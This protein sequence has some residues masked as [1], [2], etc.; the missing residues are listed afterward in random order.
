M[1]PAGPNRWLLVEPEKRDLE[2]ALFELTTGMDVAVVD[3]SH[4]RGVLRLSGPKVRQVLAKGASLDFHEQVFTADGAAQTLLF[5]LSVLIDCVG[6][7]PSF[8]IYAA[9]GFCLS[10]WQSLCHAGAEYGYRVE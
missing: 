10:L 5:H 4:A 8:D 6:D 1:I 7:G 3:L 9:R 2:A